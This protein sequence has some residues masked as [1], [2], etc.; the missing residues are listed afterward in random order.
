MSHPISYQA[1]FIKR[2]Q[3]NFLTVYGFSL[4]YPLAAGSDFCFIASGE[5]CPPSSEPLRTTLLRRCS[6]AHSPSRITTSLPG[7]PNSTG[8]A[9]QPLFPVPG[10]AK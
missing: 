5:P 3:E 8:L 4:F 2:S 6:V 1:S 9:Q 7:G 10:S